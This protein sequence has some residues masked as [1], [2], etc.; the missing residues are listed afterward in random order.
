MNVHKQVICVAKRSSLHAFV[1]ALI[2]DVHGANKAYSGQHNHFS[3]YNAYNA[4]CACAVTF[5]TSDSECRPTNWC[6][7]SLLILSKNFWL[8]DGVVVL[9]TSWRIK[10]MPLNCHGF[11]SFSCNLG[12]TWW[13]WKS[14]EVFRRTVIRREI[15]RRSVMSVK[16]SRGVQASCDKARD[17]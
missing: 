9:V 11:F 7:W 5:W 15:I 12:E 17:Y 6:R 1:W 8:F 13:V 4:A 16:K 14:Q 10:T 3:A 2:I